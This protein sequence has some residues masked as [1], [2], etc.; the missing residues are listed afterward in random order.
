MIKKYKKIIF[1]TTVFIAVVMCVNIATYAYSK[2]TL[3]DVFFNKNESEKKDMLKDLLVTDGRSIEYDGYTFTLESEL[4]DKVAGIGYC[5]FTIRKQGMDMRDIYYDSSDVEMMTLFDSFGDEARFSIVPDGSK[6]KSS[7]EAERDILNV[8]VRFERAKESLD[9]NIYICDFKYKD[10]ITEI[11]EHPIVGERYQIAAKFELKDSNCSFKINCEN[12]A[13]IIVNP[14]QI[15]INDFNNEINDFN[16]QMKDGSSI[17]LMKD[18][19]ILEQLDY[20]S[21]VVEDNGN[22]VESFMLKDILDYREVDYLMING[23]KY[24]E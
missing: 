9:N 24:S 13:E 15:S 3:I 8:Y 14:F 10:S 19:K 11:L 6:A 5:H 7:F 23:I 12:N 2:K 18:G 20:H 16:I 17:K 22:K 21:S 4:Y 1:V